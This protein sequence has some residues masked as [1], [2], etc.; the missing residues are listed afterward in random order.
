MKITDPDTLS[1]DLLPEYRFDYSTARPNRFAPRESA[2]MTIKLDA[3]VAAIF[4]TEE[5]V[6]VVL[7]ALIQTMP[8]A[9]QRETRSK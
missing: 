7:R 2:P 8:H 4:T 1:D 6:N 9:A 5:S 3:D